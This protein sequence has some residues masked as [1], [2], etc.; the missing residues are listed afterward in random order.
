[1]KTY[2][3]TE[4]HIQNN[5]CFDGRC[6]GG[7]GRFLGYDSHIFL[8]TPIQHIRREYRESTLNR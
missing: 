1:M 5:V 8:S 6:Q 7:A 4:K 3:E 2:I